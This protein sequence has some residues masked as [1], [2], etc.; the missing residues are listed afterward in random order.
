MNNEKALEV[1]R[2]HLTETRYRHTIGVYETSSALAKAYGADVQKAETAAILHDICKYHDITKMKQTVVRDL[3]EPHWAEYGVELLHAPCGAYYVETE[4]GIGDKDILMAIRS[5][6]TGRAGMSLL[7][8]VVFVADYIEPTRTFLGVDKARELAKED[9][10][11]ACLFA[12]EQT[13]DYLRKK[14]F[15]V[16]PQTEEAYQYLVNQK[17]DVHA[18]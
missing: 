4:L 9:L 6:T 3:R 12:L 1:V 11:Q 7:E 5:H 10:D 8:K 17:G 2:P 14:G 16:H 15:P 13:K 18:E